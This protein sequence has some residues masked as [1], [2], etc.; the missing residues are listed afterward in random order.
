MSLIPSA[1]INFKEKKIKTIYTYD[2]LNRLTSE[3][4]QEY[5]NGDL[6]GEFKDVYS[7]DDYNNI[8][9]KIHI[10]NETKR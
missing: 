1:F 4:Q 7:F 10:E 9:Q 6:S 3:E 5:N 2:R 8:L